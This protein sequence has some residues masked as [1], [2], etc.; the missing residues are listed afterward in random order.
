MEL[1]RFDEG[2]QHRHIVAYDPI[3]SQVFA[4]VRDEVHAA[5]AGVEL[6]TS[7]ARRSCACAA[8]P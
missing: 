8:N 6:G 7:A 2:L 5:L 1:E 4:R 3:Y